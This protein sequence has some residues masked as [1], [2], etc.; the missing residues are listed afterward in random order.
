MRDFTEKRLRGGAGETGRQKVAAAAGSN[1]EVQRLTVSPRTPW[2]RADPYSSSHM[3]KLESLVP[4]LGWII[5]GNH[6]LQNPCPCKDI[7]QALPLP[8]PFYI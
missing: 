6:G 4:G 7:E 8:P 2:V 3:G 1:Q 5:K